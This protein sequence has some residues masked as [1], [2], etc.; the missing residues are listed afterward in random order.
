MVGEDKPVDDGVISM[1]E[2]GGGVEGVTEGA[3]GGDDT[4]GVLVG[5]TASEDAG[6]AT[7]SILG[8]GWGGVDADEMLI[9][10]LKTG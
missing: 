8:W 6:S 7:I 9:G 4:E 3:A 1:E 10:T 2:S 5:A